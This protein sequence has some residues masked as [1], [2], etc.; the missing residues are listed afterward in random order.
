MK[1]DYDRPPWWWRY[2]VMFWTV[3][4]W[5]LVT[6]ALIRYRWHRIYD[7]LMITFWPYDRWPREWKDLF[8]RRRNADK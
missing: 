7:Y 1:D 5:I 8:S 2:R 6:P 4:T 3:A